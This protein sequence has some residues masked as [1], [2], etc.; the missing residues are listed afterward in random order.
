MDTLDDI[1]PIDPF[2]PPEGGPATPSDASPALVEAGLGLRVPP[3]NIEVE[4]GLLGALLTNNLAFERVSDFLLPEHFAEPVHGRIYA[5]IKAV[6][7]NGEIADAARLK[8]MFDQ[9]GALEEIGGGRYLLELQA[10]VVSIINANDYARTIYDMH[11]RRQLI[12]LGEIVVNDAFQIDLENPPMRQIEKA[13]EQ[14]YSLADSGEIENGPNS[15]DKILKSTLDI[16]NAAVSREGDY[17]GIPSGFRDLDQKLG[18]L[19][20]SDL[21]ILAARPAMGKTALVT[22]MAFNAA[23]KAGGKVAFFSLEMA[24]EQLATRMLS[25]QSGVSSENI[26]KGEINSDEFN[27]I[28]TISRDLETLDFFIDDTPALP[29]SSLR[30]RARRLKRQY[31]GLD[32]IVVDYLQLMQGKIGGSENRVQEISEI[33]RGLKGIAKELDVP[34]IALS[35]LSRQVE[36][37]EDKRP[38]LADLRESGSIEQDADVVMFIYR[39][40]YYEQSK[41]P[42]KRGDE[43]EGS[44]QARMS[45]WQDHMSKIHNQALVIISKNRH[46]PT[47]EVKL[48]FDGSTTRFSDYIDE[49]RFAGSPGY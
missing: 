22:N 43:D 8:T 34:V 11:L 49:D 27:K 32:L 48:F 10:A 39:E 38:Q 4:Q 47:G 44:F 12:D 16:I 24:S 35:Q 20:R 23:K 21:I 13:E 5:A 2:S 28:F 7:E 14:L 15:F 29:V 33:T 6:I 26:R 25:E 41:I 18:G 45:D 9:D 30:T 17:T 42:I 36:N 3:K 19:N 1:P 40:S 46:G 37:R 31:G